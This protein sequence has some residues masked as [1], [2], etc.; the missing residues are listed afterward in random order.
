MEYLSICLRHL[1]FLSPVSYNFL[2]TVLLSPSVQFSSFMSDSLQPH[3][4]QH[5]RLPCPLPTPRAYSNSCPSCWWCHPII[6]SSVVPFSSHFQSFPA[7]GLFKWVG[8][9][10]QMAKVL[11]FSFSIHP[12]SEYSGL[13]SFRMD[14]LD[15]LAVQGTL[16]S[17]LQ[18]F[19]LQYSYTHQ[20]FGLLLWLSW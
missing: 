14:W 20:C 13:I 18:H 2:C 15:L 7:Q 5:G 1:W 6:S 11:E 3:E 9:S 4:L 17:L 19:P 10:H 16:K 8:S 12:S